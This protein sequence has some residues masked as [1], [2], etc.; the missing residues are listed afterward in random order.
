MTAYTNR[1]YSGASDL[2]IM[3]AMIA[4]CFTTQSMRVGDL[5]WLSRVATHRTLAN[6]IHLWE[7]ATGLVGWTFVRDRGGFNVFADPTSAPDSLVQEM[8]DHVESAVA[9]SLAAGDPPRAPYTYGVDETRSEYDQRLAE[10]LRERGF[11]AIEGGDGFLERSLDDVPEPAPLPPGYRIVDGGAE[12][13]TGRVEAQREAFAP[14]DFTAVQYERV[15]SVWP[16]RPE[17]E[18]LVLDPDGVVAAFCTSWIDDVNHAGLLEPVGTRPAWQRRGLA[19]AVCI[20][21]LRALRDAS[22]RVANI[23][24][25]TDAAFRLYTSIGFTPKWRDMLFRREIAGTG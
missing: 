19:R 15:R 5:A 13:A 22:A 6:D 10:A 4:R 9:R 14:S 2:R 21:A 20:D 25:D 17:L 24:Y 3:Q 1:E 7:D 18:R 23:A 8:L 11:V 16:Y 12:H